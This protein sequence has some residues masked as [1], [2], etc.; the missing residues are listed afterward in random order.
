MLVKCGCGFEESFDEAQLPPIRFCPYCGE[1]KR[2]DF[3][4]ELSKRKIPESRIGTLRL[5]NWRN[6]FTKPLREKK[7]KTVHH[8]GDCCWYCGCTET[9][10]CLTSGGA[11]AWVIRPRN[12][13]AGVC[14]ASKCLRALERDT[15]LWMRALNRGEGIQNGKR[16]AA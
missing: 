4:D 9:M 14:S 5:A 6:I 11:C 10:P 12:G 16:R 2:L 1:A 15:R 13:L 3:Y 8:E 7:D